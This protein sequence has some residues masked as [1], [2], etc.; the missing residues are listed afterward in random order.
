M[1]I[2]TKAIKIDTTFLCKLW[3]LMAMLQLLIK[4]PSLQIYDV[5][6][7]HI[8]YIIM[9]LKC[10][11]ALNAQKTKANSIASLKSNLQRLNRKANDSQY[12][13]ANTLDCTP[14]NLSE[15]KVL[16]AY[17]TREDLALQ[18]L[19]RQRDR[20]KIYVSTKTKNCLCIRTTLRL[21]I[22]SVSNV[23]KLCVLFIPHH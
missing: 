16:F 7:H 14:V 11:H 10:L 1:S 17:I 5:Q 4:I 18:S 15:F 6:Y 19:Q 13:A 23:T 22:Q 20:S 3:P 2:V 9:S 21:S 8:N 12:L